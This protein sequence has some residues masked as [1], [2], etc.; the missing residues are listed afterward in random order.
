MI[1]GARNVGPK[2]FGENRLAGGI[3]ARIR[4]TNP[5][6]MHRKAVVQRNLRVRSVFFISVWLKC[7]RRFVEHQDFRGADLIE[8]VAAQCSK[9]R[10]KALQSLTGPRKTDAMDYKYS[11]NRFA[12]RALILS[13]DSQLPPNPTSLAADAILDPLRAFYFVQPMRVQ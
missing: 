6:S 12:C 2:H 9:S 4:H 5:A 8:A 10:Y 11:P 7:F 3:R 13:H 1:A